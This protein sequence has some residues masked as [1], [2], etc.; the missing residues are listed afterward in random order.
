M[1]VGASQSD[2]GHAFFA[3]HALADSHFATGTALAILAN[4]ISYIYDLRGPSLA[5]DTA[6]SS[7]LVALHQA[8]EALR[9]G[10]I[11]T[12]IV[13]GINIV[14]SPASF[15][16]FSQA[17]MLSPTGLCHSF[18]A[19]ADGFVRA[20]GGAILVLRKAAHAQAS[21]NPV[22]GLV[23]ATDVNSDGRTNGIS[24]PSGDAQSLLQRIYSR[25][26]I[27]PD[28]LAF[29]EA[30]GTG[31]AAGDPIEATDSVAASAAIARARFPI[32]P[33]KTNIGHLEPASGLAGVLKALLA[34][35]HGILPSLLHCSG[36]NPAIDFERLNRRSAIGIGAGEWAGIAWLRPVGRRLNL[37]LL[38]LS[39]PEL[40]S[41]AL[42]S[43]APHWLPKNLPTSSPPQRQ[44]PT[45][46]V[47]VRVRPTSLRL[48]QNTW[49]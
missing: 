13:G 9:S 23:L 21:R 4:R 44:P 18:S 36:T 37:P 8:V 45:N 1:F 2:Y 29:V 19:D 25:A 24:L 22:H 10:R 42:S 11:D 32:G 17:S 3:D 7:S 38:R 46:A 41:Y 20:E 47:S 31:T 43:M 14:A 27:E 26:G 40:W 5:V 15:I 34:L 6:C 33:I 48:D 12:A 28:R 39:F 49:L 16:A 35:N 30:H